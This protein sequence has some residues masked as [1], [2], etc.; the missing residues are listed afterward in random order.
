MA[1][2]KTVSAREVAADIR[3][4]ATD[5][6]LM[7]KYGV[8]EKGLQNLFQKLV[9][10][11]VLTQAKLAA[12]KLATDD[13]RD[14]RG[15]EGEEK[16]TF[17]HPASHPAEPA[18][19]CPACDMPLSEASEACPR[20]G[21]IFSKFK[22][23]PEEYGEQLRHVPIGQ[24]IRRLADEEAEGPLPTPERETIKPTPTVILSF[25]GGFLLLIGLFA[26]V[27][28]TSVGSVSLFKAKLGLALL[29]SVCSLSGGILPVLHYNKA[30]WIPA[31]VAIVPLTYYYRSFKTLS[32]M[33]PAITP[34]FD[35]AIGQMQG[36]ELAKEFLKGMTQALQFKMGW[37]WAVLF[38]GAGIMLIAAITG[39]LQSN[40]PK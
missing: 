7:K 8:S 19:K 13:M 27:L 5:E 10:A 35:Q 39:S 21:V 33:M 28:T 2:K 23:R 15:K 34:A 30:I 32:S 25:L 12:R 26:P 18:S 31:L 38:I 37:G 24:Q 4:G 3:A 22:D 9:T 6:S 17:P 29:L 16:S 40:K 36:N 11:K 1:E 20:C 14:F